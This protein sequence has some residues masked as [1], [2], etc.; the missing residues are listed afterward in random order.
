[1]KNEVSTTIWSPQQICKLVIHFYY[2][3][4]AATIALLLAFCHWRS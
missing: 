3:F 1:M 4:L 2:F